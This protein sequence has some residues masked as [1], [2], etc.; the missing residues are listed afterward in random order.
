MIDR[1]T[2]FVEDIKTIGEYNTFSEQL[3]TLLE[4]I[5][6]SKDIHQ[7]LGMAQMI[8]ANGN[9]KIIQ[10]K[11]ILEHQHFSMYAPLQQMIELGKKEEILNEAIPN[12]L[13]LGLIFQSITIP[14][15]NSI[16]QE[17]FIQAIKEMICHGIY[18]K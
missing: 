3:D 2:K 12:E 6:E 11:K 1:M 16:K 17:K 8:D 15:M 9:E 10:K 13:M 5:F 4:I 7:V 18:K 14:N